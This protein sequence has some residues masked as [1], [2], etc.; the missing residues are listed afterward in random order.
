MQKRLSEYLINKVK[1]LKDKK[2]FLRV[3]YNVPIENNKIKEKYRIVESFKTIDYL[4][5]NG[6]RVFIVSHLGDPEKFSKK[7][8]LQ[9]LYPFLKNK[10]KNIEFLDFKKTKELFNGKEFFGN[11]FLL[12]NIRFFNDK[13]KDLNFAKNIAK[14]FQIYVN[15]AFSASHREHI[16]T[17]LI[18]K[19]L[20]TYF[21][22]RFYEEIKNLSFWKKNKKAL[23]ILGGKKISTKYPLIKNFQKDPLVKKIILC[24]GILNYYLKSIG[25]DIKKSYYE[26]DFNKKLSSKKILKITDV[27]F[28]K[29]KIVDIGPKGLEEIFSEIKKFNGIIIWNGPIGIVEQKPFEEGTK[30]LAI[31]LSKRKNFKIVGG[32]DTLAFLE[33]IKILNKFNYISTGGGAMLHFLAYRT[34][35]ILKIGRFSF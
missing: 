17:F 9:I 15:E 16:S 20:P 33:K 19:F 30:K 11:I 4:I 13:T 29:N 3:D 7:Y 31:F 25:F 10:F 1:N 2:I 35:P 27:V 8:S 5:K 32:G 6:A 21:G 23:L 24:G 12:E 14:N 26:K 28:Y 22:F 34:L 18:S